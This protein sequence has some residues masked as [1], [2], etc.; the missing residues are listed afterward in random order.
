[1]KSKDK[2]EIR[3]EYT[4][5]SGVSNHLF[6]FVMLVMFIIGLIAAYFNL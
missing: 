4:K 5:P 6:L 3:S 1:M 2:N